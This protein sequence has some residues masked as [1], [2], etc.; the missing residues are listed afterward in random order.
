MRNSLFTVLVADVRSSRDR[1]LLDRTVRTRRLAVPGIGTLLVGLLG[2]LDALLVNARKRAVRRHRLAKNEEREHKHHRYR[3]KLR[4]GYRPSEA[5]DPLAGTCGEGR[6]H[7]LC[8]GRAE[9]DIKDLSVQAGGH[10]KLVHLVR[11]ASRYRADDHPRHVFAPR[12]KSG[13]ALPAMKDVG[14]QKPVEIIAQM[15][16]ELVACHRRP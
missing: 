3:S 10:L 4:D 8:L 15:P 14:G 12:A 9:R 7:F 6:L 11:I 1:V 5:A 16:F 13:V 2:K